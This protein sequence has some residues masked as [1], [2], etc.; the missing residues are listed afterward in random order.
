MRTIARFMDA[1]NTAE[2]K[3]LS[4]L[5]SVLLV[6]SFLNVTMFTD[7]AGATEGEEATSFVGEKSS[8]PMQEVTE[9][10][11][12]QVGG[13]K[14]ATA[15]DEA[16]AS[17]NSAD[18]LEENESNKISTDKDFDKVVEDEPIAKKTN[19]GKDEV[20]A[21]S[22][23]NMEGEV[24]EAEIT[25]DAIDCPFT[26]EKIGTGEYVI[27]GEG[28]FSGEFLFEGKKTTFPKLGYCAV[29]KLTLE[30]GITGIAEDTFKEYYVGRGLR[31]IVL[32]TTLTTI[33]ARAFYGGVLEKI[34][35]DNVKSIGSEAFSAND[36]LSSYGNGLTELTIPAGMTEV[37]PNAFS[38]MRALTKVTIEEG[39]S[40]IGVQA[41]MSCPKLETIIIPSTLKK[42]GEKAFSNCT[43]LQT[44]GTDE[45]KCVFVGIEC[46]G[47]QAFESSGVTDVEI[48]GSGTTILEDYAFY[49]LRKLSSLKMESIQSVG[50]S[51]FS[52]CDGLQDVQLE[53]VQSVGAN[54]FCYCDGLQNVLLRDIKNIG[55]MVFAYCP[56][57]QNLS[58]RNV[59]LPD[60]A[61]PFYNTGSEE[62][63]IDADSCN[64]GTYSFWNCKA[65]KASLRNLEKIGQYTFYQSPAL[66]N[67]E[68]EN[69]DAL[70]S[71]CFYGC[72]ELEHIDGIAEVSRID[73]YAFYGCRNLKGLTIE[74]IT[75][76]GF[77]GNYADVSE[78]VQAILAGRFKLDNAPDITE[79]TGDDWESVKVSKSDNWN[80]Y[81][82]GMQIVQQARWMEGTDDTVAEVKVDAYYTGQKQMD[83]VFVADLSSSMAQLGNNDDSNA[84]VYDMQSKLLDMSSEL[85]NSNDFYDCK[86]AMVTFGGLFQGKQTVEATGFIGEAAELNN[87]IKGLAPYYENT[88]YGLGLSEAL[89]LVQQNKAAGRNTTVIFLTDGAPT[90]NGSGDQ[91]GTTAAQ[92]IRNEGAQIFGVLHS[93]PAQVAVM[94][95][96][97]DTYYASHDTESF[98]M[99]MN[100]AF[101]AAYP[102]HTVTIAVNSNFG[103]V[104][105]LE[106]SV[107]SGFASY[108]AA[109]H[110]IVWTLDQAM[111]FTKHTLTYRQILNADQAELI[112]SHTYNTNNGVGVITGASAS[113]SVESPQLSR[114]VAEPVL[115]GGY[116]V[117]HEYYTDGEL[118]GT[119]TERLTAEVGTVVRASNVPA[120]EG[121]NGNVYELTQA[122]GSLTVTKDGD[123]AVTLR[124]YR[125]TTPAP[126]PTPTPVPTPTPTVVV[127]PA[128][129][130]SAPTP[131]APAAPATPAP[132]APAPAA[133][134]A[135]AAPVPV[136]EPIEDDAT[137][138]AA[139]AAERTPL[140]ETEE[141]EDEAT[142]MGAFDEPH[143]WVHW[144]M[145]LGILI[146]AAY[147]LV[148]VRR[149]L[150]LADD[151]DDYE[152][153]VLGIEDEAPEAVPADGRQAL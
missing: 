34:N 110:E 10:S 111:P 143:C 140:A 77:N 95:E 63:N 45:G 137:P 148:V 42:I 36:K 65:Q 55:S 3:F 9:L 87:S 61:Y 46:I 120:R 53:K 128:A 130:T 104:Q 112:G 57:L 131:A 58:M 71:Y 1:R 37:D 82:D 72:S 124:Y 106:V 97:C 60:K 19:S 49:G 132:A 144:V 93:A 70:G 67:V 14:N 35:L 78:R 88:D 43:A 4:V 103:E 15:T 85:L 115:I 91:N 147:G 146:T 11:D 20:S 50:T 8:G 149:R 62:M 134:P 129:V 40:S 21:L 109:R 145:L 23:V 138:Q 25:E 151:V 54:A 121:Y 142:P 18:S 125:T 28:V 26:A 29:K 48:K 52:Y 92:A 33:G 22:V 126:I 150:H 13:E 68:L 32:P 105:G 64:L 86:I 17:E 98:G 118:D 38:G 27:S 122:N 133:A 51:A 100:L 123:D 136:A 153:Q 79:I 101:A 116:R 90:A 44:I 24:S 7:Y 74:D 117:V 89:K 107:S 135:A 16:D 96:I 83:Y 75:K 56:N 141:I 76:M 6:F 80:T 114:I 113:V 12:G 127:T 66:K 47:S 119:Y 5:L 139:A 69:V 30:E 108:D 94:D 102:K 84:R 41:F 31:E 2:G 59:S 152:K 39:V 81:E 99:A 73:G